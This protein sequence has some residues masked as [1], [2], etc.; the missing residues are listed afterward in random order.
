MTKSKLTP[1]L[2]AGLFLFV[3]LII[4]LEN[5]YLLINQTRTNII[6]TSW[7][8]AEKLINSIVAGAK[9]SIEAVQLTDQQ[10][11]RHI[12]KIAGQIDQLYTESSS[13]AEEEF[14]EIVKNFKLISFSIF[15][16]KGILLYALHQD[17][18][19]FGLQ[20]ADLLRLTNQKELT[21]FNKL[22]SGKFKGEIQWEANM[23]ERSSKL[24]MLTI[25][26]S[27]KKGFIRIFFGHEKLQEIRSRIG[28]LLLINSL[29]NQNVIQYVSFMN[30]QLVIIADY[31]PSRVDTVEEKLEY[32]DALNQGVS[33]YN[34]K[35][36][37]QEF[38]H[39]LL[40]TKDTNGVFRI[41]FRMT[42][43]Q[44]IYSDT[45]KITIIN[46]I[47][48]MLIATISAMIMLIFHKRNIRKMDAMTQKISENEKLES[49][50]ILT[51]G[52]AHE[53]R[54]PLNSI[55]ITI[56]R[57]QMEFTP[58]NEQDL[59]DYMSL[60]AT[61][62]NE[63][64]RLNAIITDFLDFAKPFTP[65]NNPFT[66]DDFVEENISFL[67]AEAQKRNIQ[68]EK[69]IL[70]SQTQ[71]LGDREKLTQV[72]QNLFFNA[73]EATP[74]GGII[75]IY[76]NVTKDQNWQLRIQDNG[77]GVAARDFT[78]IFDIYFTTKKTGTGLGL[79]ISRKIIQAHHGSIELKQNPIKGMSAIVTLPINPL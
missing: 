52:V 24:H 57:L 17:V 77:E 54:N 69:H 33:F 19:P 35:D 11:Q 50:A 71:F 59:V 76:S 4:L 10:I 23:S 1:Y 75:A 34:K 5:S 63:V 37:I 53:V 29:E 21:A 47:I 38:V 48:I 70:T 51:A 39:P 67:S 36:D 30:D 64:D 58:K 49:L 18:L 6:E 25:T 26:R 22:M 78:H 56:Q 79:Y 61:M 66:L 14:K 31:E 46:S 15:N 72:L 42:G 32:L 45:S 74:E 41:A 44:Q 62:K 73:L 43:L 9:Q 16:E 2:Y 68:I 8:D 13:R 3:T 20:E 12:K 27:T 55:S 40:L 28:L 65:K 7:L 60:T